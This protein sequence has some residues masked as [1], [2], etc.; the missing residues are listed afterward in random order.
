MP[1]QSTALCLPRAALPQYIPSPGAVAAVVHPGMAAAAHA[2]WGG[3]HVLTAVRSRACRYI[4]IVKG[5]EGMV[6]SF[7]CGPSKIS[8][9]QEKLELHGV[10]GEPDYP[11]FTDVSKLLDD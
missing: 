8:R 2:S 7:T 1:H 9:L 3:L 6:E 5:S 10:R 4:Q 11:E